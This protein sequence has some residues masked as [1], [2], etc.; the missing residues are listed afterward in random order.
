M[1]MRVRQSGRTRI[2]AGSK[3][4]EE[5]ARKG[6]AAANGGGVAPLMLIVVKTTARANALVLAPSFL[7]PSSRNSLSIVTIAD[8][9]AVGSIPMRLFSELPRTTLSLGTLGMKLLGRGR[10]LL[11]LGIPPSPLLVPTYSLRR[12]SI[13]V[14]LF[15]IA[16]LI[17]LDMEGKFNFTL[18]TMG[19]LGR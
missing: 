12:R 7:N 13:I 17:N 19:N 9:M 15:M 3:E 16:F 2:S 18:K 14:L 5:S 1:G 8:A 6:Y 11:S 10:L 4:E